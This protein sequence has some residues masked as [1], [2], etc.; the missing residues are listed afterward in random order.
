MRTTLDIDDNVL[1]AARALARDSGTSI[2]AVVSALARRG[3]EPAPTGHRNG[4]PV[5][6]AGPDAPA[7][8]PELVN[9]FR[10]SP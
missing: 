3:L 8:T 6:D 5:F 1:A 2:G 7:I 10:D 4:F 9:E